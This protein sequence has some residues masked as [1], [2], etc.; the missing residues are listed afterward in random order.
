MSSAGSS[1]IV[2]SLPQLNFLNLDDNKLCQRAMQQ[3]VTGS[4]PYLEDLSIVYQDMD[5]SSVALLQH[6]RWSLKRL[7]HYT[8][9][10]NVGYDHEAEVSGIIRTDWPDMESLS[11]A[12]PD[13]RTFAKLCKGNW[14]RLQHLFVGIERCDA[15]LIKGLVNSSWGELESLAFED[16]HH[17]SVCIIIL[18]HHI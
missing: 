5:A 11:I 9:K 3:L 17:Q 1:L 7:W 14:S 12:A 4:W 15:I 10:Q 16:L 6:A 13:H 18:W 8:G 2:A